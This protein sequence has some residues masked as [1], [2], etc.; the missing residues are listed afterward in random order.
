MCCR[1]TSFSASSP[2][3]G[4]SRSSSIRRGWRSGSRSRSSADGSSRRDP[5]DRVGDRVLRWS[6]ALTAACS[7]ALALAAAS[8]AAQARPSADPAP[9]PGPA[10][11]PAPEAGQAPAASPSPAPP[12]PP[13]APAPEG[14]ARE[15]GGGTEEAAPAEEAPAA[16]SAA[17]KQV[18]GQIVV[19][20]NVRVSDSAFFNSLKLKSG[21][22][23]DE[24]AVQDEYR[25]LWDLDLFDDI[26]VESRKRDS[27]TIDL[28]F[29]VR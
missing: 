18:V 14:P 26:V 12:S 15:E 11:S 23:Y 5:I 10:P 8:P 21:D 25:R 28:I 2:E 27:R 1:R 29:H 6:R 13:A 3:T 17:E 9:A 7:L 19:D 16:P 20:G 22:P 24:R 4:R